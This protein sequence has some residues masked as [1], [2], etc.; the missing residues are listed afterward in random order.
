MGM[1]VGTDTVESS[2]G[3]NHAEPSGLR[4]SFRILLNNIRSFRKKRK[5]KLNHIKKKYHSKCI[6]Q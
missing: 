6:V 4:K 5:N 2:G 3:S 1:G